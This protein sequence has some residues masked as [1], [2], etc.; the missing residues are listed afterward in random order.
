MTIRVVRNKAGNCINFV[1]TT[2]PAYWNACLSA[3]V[4]ETDPTAINVINDIRT[5]NEPDTVYEFFR[6]PYTEFVDK[7]G[8]GFGD[9]NAVAEY[10]TSNAN[11]ATNVGNDILVGSNDSF[12]FQT[13]VSGTTIFID[14]GDA[15]SINELQALD[16]G[17]GTITITKRFSSNPE[18]VTVMSNLNHSNVT[19]AGGSAGVTISD[20][21][22]SLNAIF[23]STALGTG[24]NTIIPSIVTDGGVPVSGNDAEGEIPVTGNPTHILVAGTDISGHGARY[25]SDET[26]SAAGEYFTVKITG[27]GKFIL[28]LGSEADGDRADMVNDL[29]NSSTGLLFG[30]ALYDFGSYIGPYNTYGSSRTYS[31]GPGWTGVDSELYRYNGNI[32]TAHDN[33]DPVLFRVGIDGQGYIAVWYYDISRSNDWV[34][35]SRRSFNT[36]Q[37]EYFLVVKLCDGN[38]TLVETPLRFGEDPSA[39]TLNWRF[40]ESPD[41][42]F[43]HPLFGSAD[44]A[45]YV[46]T[47]NGGIGVGS[48][49][50]QVYPDEPSAS[51][52]YMPF[53]GSFSGV[54]SAPTNTTDRI[55]TEIPTLSDENFKPVDLVLGDKQWAE[56]Y[57][58]NLQI[59]PAGDI[60]ATV[61]G[62]PAGL[63]YNN[64]FITGSTPYVS[65]D[66]DYIITVT[67]T[68]VYGSNIQTFNMTIEDNASLGDISGFTETGGNFLQPNR[69]ILDEDALLQYDNQ[70]SPGEELTYSYSVGQIPPTFGILSGVG[71][72]NLADF[73]PNTDTLGTL[74]GSNN[75][76]ETSNWSLRYVSFGGFIGGG[77]SGQKHALVG[78]TDNATQSGA[79]G[80][81]TDK[82]FKLEYGLDGVFR[83]YVDNTLRLTSADT[84]TGP[85]T[86]TL[87]A[88]DDQQQTD[89][90]IP[91]NLA[92]T[93]SAAGTTTPPAG[94]VDPVES[95]VMSTN[96]VFGPSDDGAVFLT[97]T[98]KVNH[99][100]IVPRAWIEANV[101]P[102]IAGSGAGVGG[103][104]FF[105]GVPKDTANFSTINEVDNYHAHFRLEG[106]TSSHIS[107]IYTSGTGGISENNVSVSSTTS[108][109]YDYAI[110][111]DGTDL[112]VIAC[113]IGDINT[114]PGINNGGTFSRIA[115]LPNFATDHGK[116]NTE[117]NLVIAIKDSASVNL[118]TS[119]L[120]Q[121]RIPFGIRDVLVGEYANGHSRF[122]LNPAASKYDDAPSGHSWTNAP[123][124]A[125][126]L[127]AGYTY[128]FIYHPSLEADDAIKFIRADDGSDYAIGVTFFDGS[129]VAGDPN[130]TN[131]YKGV[132]FAV[133][134]DAPPLNLAYKNSYQGNT[135]YDYVVDLP[136]SGSTYTVPVEVDGITQIGPNGN[137]TG[138]NWSDQGEYGFIQVDELVGAGERITFPAAFWHDLISNS[139]GYNG[140]N[141]TRGSEFRFGFKDTN[142][143]VNNFNVGFPNDMW[144]GGVRLHV[145]HSQQTVYFRLYGDSSGTYYSKA[146]N[147]TNILGSNFRVFFEITNSGN[148]IR[149]AMSTLS[150]GDDIAST[151]FSEWSNQKANTGDQGFGITSREFIMLRSVVFN[152]TPALDLQDID[153]SVINEVSM[154]SA[155]APLTTPWNTA[156]DFSGSSERTQQVANSTTYSPIM[157]GGASSQVALPVVSTNTVNNGHPWATAIVFKI[158]G[159]SSNQHIWNFG[160]GSGASDDNIYLR[161]DSSQRLFFGWGRSGEVNECYIHTLSSTWWYGIYVGFNGARYGAAGSTA[162]RLDSIFDIRL[163]SSIDS[164]GSLSELTDLQASQPGWYHG[165][166]STGARMDRQFSGVMTIGG[167]RS[168]R[169]FHG[170]VASM[171]VTTLRTGQPMPSDAEINM[172]IT[173]PL[174]WAA[175]YKVGNPYRSS[176]NQ[177]E[178]PSWQFNDNFSAS[179]AQIW[180]M[181]DGTGDAYAQIRNQVF[182][183]TQNNTPLNMISMVSNDIETVNIP[184]LT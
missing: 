72:S 177:A 140:Q 57:N 98:L 87:A 77:G 111:W 101:L 68:N 100:Y 157:M 11:V 175:Q 138:T 121:I 10:I 114:Q 124:L 91:T 168:N 26:I 37:G 6:I 106:A 184:G 62:L 180:L 2:N 131:G 5:A 103:E 54:S 58:V 162:S 74:Q 161:L 137:Q 93:N 13:D 79:E 133:P 149:A 136:I 117:L 153:F 65:K 90:Y 24:G 176:L 171:V 126:T 35:I 16:A 19:I 67:R 28:G 159:N 42:V 108:A 78:W 166:S 81:L 15:Y 31:Y 7:D 46:D 84:Y 40:I 163:T 155:P 83:L 32:Q 55:Y 49:I 154:P 51:V 18:N 73:D 30:Q 59:V 50:A 152:N 102:N 110:E 167:R 129:G 94:F 61:S 92:I 60:P 14:N 95:G 116:T 69:V 23:T 71:T 179:T 104:R 109:F 45:A 63:F 85:Q 76:A 97:E 113:N 169:S 86:L 122:E 47:E 44:E 135:Q 141:G 41:G 173:D 75:F 146:I 165:A 12:D 183:A 56:N 64:G 36:V 158:D 112:H 170:K 148:S 178:N 132:E 156:L 89:V 70:I 107:R 33:L 115:T 120:Q 105:F 20:V 174:E 145:V 160:E 1:G 99:R 38:A 27:R 22:N 130:F 17:D 21:V 151:P 29:G 123:F 150:A 142:F 39:P 96:T 25:W 82:E 118:T 9:A 52:W 88:F 34:L 147:E 125:P 43:Y 128:R 143:D 8:N 127:N 80:T 182:P 164:F 4:D 172:M 119:G 181:G 66:T 139:P 3:V 53:N 48:A 144:E 134:S